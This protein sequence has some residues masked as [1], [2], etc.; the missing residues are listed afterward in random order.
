MKR[1][2]NTLLTIFYLGL[3]ICTSCQ[4]NP[5]HPSSL[6][7]PKGYPSNEATA[8]AQLKSYPLP[9]YLPKNHLLRL[10]DWMDPSYMG[11][12]GQVNTSKNY[13]TTSYLLM[14][15]LAHNWN[16]GI[17]SSIPNGTIDG[18]T[19]IDTSGYNMIKLANE[20]PQIP[21]DVITFW[22]GYKPIDMGYKTRVAEVLKRNLDSTLYAKFDLYGTPKREIDFNF[23]DSLIQI[24]GKAIAFTLRKMEKFLKRPISRINENGEE[25]P[26]AY[27]I[28][29][30]A[31]DPLMIKMK[32]SMK[33]DSWE[34]FI[35][36][37]KLEMRNTYSSQFLK[38]VP[39][40]NNTFF[41][42]YTVE[43]GPIDRFKWSIM[44]KCMTPV[45]GIYYSTP[46]FYPR[47][48]KNWKDWTGAWHGWKWIEIGRTIEMKDGDY[49]FSP[50]V[51]AGWSHK[52]EENI[53]PGQ[54]L[55]L[56]KC[57]S[58]I[59]AEF[60]Y[61]GYF[62]LNPP[63][64]NPADYAWQAAMPAYAQA[65]TSRFED[66]LKDGNVLFDS[67]K[68]P[69]ISYPTDDRHVLL[70]A[71]KQN[72]KEKY[73]IGGTYQP[74]SND[75]DE[76]V[77]KRNVTVSINGHTL[78]FEIRRQGSIYIYEKTLD[79]R[80]IFYQL[81]KW[82]E[83]AHP[84][85]WS[86][87]FYFDAEVADSGLTSSDIYTTNTG[88][89]GDYTSYVTYVQMKKNKNYLYTFTDRDTI[90]HTHYL[91]MRYKGAGTLSVSITGYFNLGLFQ[92]TNFAKTD[93]WKWAK[94]S[95]PDG[96]DYGSPN[97]LNISLLDGGID[98]DKFVITTKGDKAPPY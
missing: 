62:N 93:E 71:R 60:Y 38:G 64:N 90:N 68:Q 72:N 24:D 47:W 86:K 32:E 45:N 15:E 18:N 80:T 5:P 11:G 7:Y 95:L 10:F 26:G 29:S 74:F 82:H 84:D 46:D 6:Q 9:R 69:I 73:V 31:N 75:S 77:E 13:A 57:L 61:V 89:E 58:V 78:S 17:V 1:A 37:R 52:N 2:Q 98:L 19:V 66:V 3:A 44:K 81:D 12:R 36:L 67:N 43:G 4:D 79:S 25:P 63:F 50:F 49:L 39:Q 56:L 76:I 94:I 55:G 59:G 40:L 83:D 92:K 22:Q 85:N 96:Y 42:F 70:V 88:D 8:L 87:D 51:A 91:W 23:P 14:S 35:A 97:T 16:Y 41:S 54:W 65:I 27:R 53:T 34:D 21:F 20:N 48:P 30:I 33:I 28:R